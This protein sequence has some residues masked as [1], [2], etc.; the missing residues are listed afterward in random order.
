MCIAALGGYAV[1]SVS[2]RTG[3]TTPATAADTPIWTQLH[4]PTSPAVRSSA[5]MAYDAATKTVLLFGGAGDPGYGDLSDTWS[6]DGTTWTKLSP[7]TSPQGLTSAPMAYDAATKSVLLFGGDGEQHE[8]GFDSGD[9]WIQGTWSWNGTTWTKLSPSTSPPAGFADED[10]MVYDPATETVLYF[11]DCCYPGSETWSWNGTTWTK[12][13]PS[14]TPPTGYGESMV[15]DAAT[16]TVLL[17]LGSGQTWN[18]NGTDWIE[19]SSPISPPVGGRWSMDY[20]PATARVL[21]YGGIGSAHTSSEGAASPVAVLD[22]TWSW[23]GTTWTQLSPVTNPGP[24]AGAS[25]VYDPVTKDMVLF[26]DEYIQD[27][28]ETWILTDPSPSPPTIHSPRL[29]TQGVDPD[30][31]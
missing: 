21:L 1:A 12:L 2:N 8:I 28:D 18:W 15:Y 22:Q 17:L 13:S 6:W 26:G 20:D 24:R 27:D 5:S 30:A 29:T 3:A 4:P 10:S 14:T 16:A 23:N 7:R 19:S 25:L 9:G 11:T 31:E